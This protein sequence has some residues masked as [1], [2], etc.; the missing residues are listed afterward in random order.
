MATS[1][2]LDDEET[3]ALISDEVETLRAIYMDDV[4]MAFHDDAPSRPRLITYVVEPATAH[5]K[6]S[7]YVSFTLE[8]RLMKS[9]PFVSP[10][11][12]VKNPRGLSDALVERIYSQLRTQVISLCQ[13]GAFVIKM[14]SRISIGGYVGPSVGP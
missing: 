14:R 2:D 8:L 10:D 11:I 9:Y 1:F 12:L 7:R 13:L 4:E 3:N 5:E 6:A